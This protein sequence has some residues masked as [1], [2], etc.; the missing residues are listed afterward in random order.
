MSTKR[1][2]TKASLGMGTLIRIHVVTA[3]PELAA[4]AAID[5]AFDVFRFVE[6]ACS[7]FDEDSELSRLCQTNGTAVP[8]SPVLYQA[9]Q[10]AL[11]V[12]QY[13]EGRFD[14]TIGR[15][16]ESLG[17]NRHYL[18]G[19]VVHSGPQEEGVT[20]RDVL[21]DE[22]A[23]TVL[24]KRPLRLDLGAV[25][26]GLAI[27]LATRELRDFEGSLVYAG[28]DLYAAGLDE[29]DEPWTIG[30]QHPHDKQNIICQIK[31]QNQAVCTSGSYERPSPVKQG[32]HHIVN[33]E[34]L[35]SDDQLV[36]CT[37]VAPYAMMAD[38]FSTAAFLYG[39]DDGLQLLSDV[40]CEGLMI[41]RDLSMRRTAG[42]G[43]QE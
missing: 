8:V 5:R 14:P 6:N 41:T 31:V 16:L 19:E 7:R 43:K 35:E 27:D 22:Q 37:A 4:I 40:D 25:A 33:P 2:Y 15:P 30:I 23:Q 24:L 20:F 39:I 28:G 3:Q 1:N 36:S 26:K 18:T 13:T 10:F 11:E 12:A 32:T 17:F 21:V 38:A 9:I 34:S 29:Q 42:F